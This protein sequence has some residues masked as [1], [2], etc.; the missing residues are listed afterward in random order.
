MNKYD[1]IVIG[2]GPG[3]YVAAIK[4]AQLGGKVAVVEKEK[5]GGVCLNWGCIPTK[6]LLKTAKLYEDILR[7]EEFGIVG[8]DNSDVKVDWNLL[9]KRKDKVVKKLVSGIYMLFKKNK[10]DLFEG[11]GKVL[12]KN[13]VEVNGEVI[14]GDNLIIATGAKD[15]LPPIDG[16]ETVL[17]SGKII[18]SKGALQ[19]EEIPKDLVVIGGGVIAVEFATLFNSLGSKVTLI[20]RSSRILSSTEKEMA[21]TLQ[22]YLIRKGINIVTDTKLKSVTEDGV[23]ID[24]KGEEKLFKGDKY[25][26]SLGLKPQLKGIENLNLELDSKGFVKTNE[27]METNIKGVYAIGDLNGKFAL[28]HVASAE[29]IVAAENIMGRDSTMNYN[30]VPSCIYTFPELASVGL[31]EEEAKEKGYDITVSKFPL[32]ANGKALAEGETLGFAKII[33]DNKYGEILGVHIMASNATDMISEAIV[34]MQIEGT[35][36][37]VAKAIHP[38]PTLSEIVMEAAFGAV[39]KPIHI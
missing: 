3:G 39:D 5:L 12:D 16:L 36:Y 8:I 33:S 26:I 13:K 38:H 9:S 17:E 24:H 11:M 19:L 32:A 2:G 28:A 25:L 22:K 1:L 20:Q 37:D 29:G 6:T 34:A 31:T 23:L 4:A 21:T 30:I 15:N 7:G 35:V 10:V 14:I 27:R 18:N